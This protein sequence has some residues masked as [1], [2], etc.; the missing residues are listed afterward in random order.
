M[1]APPPPSRPQSQDAGIFTKEAPIHLSNVAHRR[2]EER[3]ADPRRLQDRDG[4][5]ESARRQAPGEV[6]DG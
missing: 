6:I 3:Q 1:V 4:R 2:S 5:Q